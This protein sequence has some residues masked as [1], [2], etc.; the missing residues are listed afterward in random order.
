MRARVRELSRASHS[1][2]TRST[3]S[4]AMSATKQCSH[5]HEVLPVAKFHRRGEQGWQSIC[6]TCRRR[7]GTRRYRA[8]KSLIEGQKKLRRDEL[9]AWYV[10]QKNGK[11]CTDCGG[12]FDPVA[13]QWDHLP[14]SSKRGHVSEL[15]RHG[16]RQ[17]LEVELAK[18]QL[19][20]ANCHAVRTF[21]RNLDRRSSAW[22]SAMPLSLLARKRADD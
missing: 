4:C 21:L 6:K 9:R 15:L 16:S 13:M 19:V 8:K 11:P 2:S 14:G 22:E 12:Y 18:C 5:C 20:C 17:A 1:C 10:A 3:Q 7:Y